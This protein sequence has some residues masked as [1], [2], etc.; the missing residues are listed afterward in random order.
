MEAMSHGLPALV[1][2]VGEL[3]DLVV[4]GVNGQLVR[5]RTGSAFAGAVARLLASAELEAQMSAAAKAAAEGFT[6]E[7]TAER[8]SHLLM[9]LE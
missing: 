6:L 7:R 2:N 8:W 4:A 1:S 9:T 3:E 5:E